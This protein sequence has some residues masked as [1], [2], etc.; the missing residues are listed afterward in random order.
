MG[1]GGYILLSLVF[2]AGCEWTKGRVFLTIHKWVGKPVCEA[3]DA[4]FLKG[5]RARNWRMVVRQLGADS[6]K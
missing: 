5:V 1:R 6:R 3:W 4:S 2:S